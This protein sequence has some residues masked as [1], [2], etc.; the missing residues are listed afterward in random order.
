[1]PIESAATFGRV[2]RRRRLARGLTQAALAE[3]AEISLNHVSLMER[4]LRTPSLDVFIQVARGLGVRPAELAG[5]L[6]A[7]LQG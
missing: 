3:A 1:M 5:E 6:D 2:L 7:E 4:G